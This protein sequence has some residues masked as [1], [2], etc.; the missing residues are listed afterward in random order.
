M[1]LLGIILASFFLIQV[2]FLCLLT[3]I[4]RRTHQYQVKKY[5]DSHPFLF[6]YAKFYDFVFKHKNNRE[7]FSN[8]IYA[9]NLARLCFGISSFVFIIGLESI[10]VSW[11]GLPFILLGLVFVYILSSDLLPRLTSTRK[12]KKIFLYGSFV[13]SLFMLV[14]FPLLL[15][16]LKITIYI[17]QKFTHSKEHIRSVREKVFDLLQETVPSKKLDVSDKNLIDAILRFKERI[18]REVM[19]PRSSVFALSQYMKIKDAAKMILE[20]NYSRIP[21]Y[22]GSLD[23]ICG[24]IFYKDF[25][26]LYITATLHNDTT[27]LDKPLSTLSKEVLYTPETRQISHLL[28]EFLQKQ[29]HIALVVDEFGAVEGIITIEDLLEEIVGEIEDEYDEQ[30]ELLFTQEK[31]SFIVDGKMTLIDIEHKCHLRIPQIGDFDTI[32]GYIIHKAGSIPDDG[33]T[34]SCDT[35]DLEV[36]ESTDRQVKK[37]KIIPRNLAFES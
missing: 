6:F 5:L 28:Q 27:L 9:K 21:L 25:L 3:Q 35:F 30:D 8:C 34:I 4:L 14:L 19:V 18:V 33:L 24:V 29:Q 10:K 26:S 7:F 1:F 17:N 23:K 12:A 20:E 2:Y 15:P 37:V 32:G 16:F 13:T 22:D 36:L 11:T 31:D